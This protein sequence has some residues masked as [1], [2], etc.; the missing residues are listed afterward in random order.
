MPPDFSKINIPYISDEVIRQR[1][2]EFRERCWGK[3]LPIDIELIV[4]RNLN[5][6]II[7]IPDL[8]YLAHTEAFL[9]GNLKEIVYDPQCQDVRIRFSIAHEIGHFILH[10]EIIAQLRPNSYEEWKEIQQAIPDAFWGRAEYQAR[11][12]AGRL[13]VP[14]ELLIAELKELRPVI[15][16]ARAEIPDLE[17]QVIK[18]HVAPKLARRFYVSDEVILRR[19]DA[20]NISPIQD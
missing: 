3:K 6:L 4:E 10:R 8:R 13:L 15:E 18:E 9:S 16:K 2:D 17:I 12:F 19:M 11:E 20:E 1:A 5:I 7:P 14:R